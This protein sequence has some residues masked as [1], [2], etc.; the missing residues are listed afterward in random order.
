MADFAWLQPQLDPPCCTCFVDG[1]LTAFFKENMEDIIEFV[2]VSEDLEAFG[3]LKLKYDCG[4]ERQHGR[5]FGG[6]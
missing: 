1:W 6:K 5:N 4:S 3:V 2:G